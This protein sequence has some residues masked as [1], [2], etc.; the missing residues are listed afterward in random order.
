MIDERDCPDRHG[1][2][3]TLIKRNGAAP[4]PRFSC[5]RDP[6]PHAMHRVGGLDHGDYGD[7]DAHR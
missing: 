5:R 4:V 2:S 1:L 3:V 7:Y 6:G